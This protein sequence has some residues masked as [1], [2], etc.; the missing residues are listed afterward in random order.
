M[1]VELLLSEARLALE[2]SDEAYRSGRGGPHD[3]VKELRGAV[4]KLIEAVETLHE[5]DQFGRD[6]GGDE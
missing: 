4:G 1:K 6:W 5:G 3:Q 2:R